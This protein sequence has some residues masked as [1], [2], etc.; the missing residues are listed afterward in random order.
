ML[1][2]GQKSEIRRA[3]GYPE[4]A[5]ALNAPAGPPYQN[6]FGL[7]GAH[8]GDRYTP[9][10][11]DLEY[12]MLDLPV[13][14]E[15]EILGA[16]SPFF[17]Q[18]FE[19]ANAYIN[20]VTT[21]G[22]ATVEAV[23]P[24]QIGTEVSSVSITIGD[25]EA[26]IATNIAAAIDALTVAP[27]VVVA[28][29]IAGKVLVEARVPGN[30]MNTFAV[31]AWGNADVALTVTDTSATPAPTFRLRGGSTPPG[32]TFTDPTTTPPTQLFGHLPIIRFWETQI[33]NAAEGMDT[34]QAGKFIQESR[35]YA[36]RRQA[37]ITACKDLAQTMAVMYFGTR[38]YRGASG[39]IRV[40]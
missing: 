15:V 37:Y 12:R 2:E 32:P 6:T 7:A 22:A 18:F 11:Y 1:T 5:T 27:T 31:R 19:P 25:T 40:Y 23:L 36:K 9:S 16:D 20:A 10:F 21:G 30:T 28:L 29:P 3:L 4:P 13:T 39:A 33:P 26:T 14:G 35:E 24:L 38:N 17:N 34:R 8:I